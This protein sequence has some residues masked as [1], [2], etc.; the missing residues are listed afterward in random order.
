MIPRIGLVLNSFCNGY[1]G[2]GVYRPLRIE[3]LGA[4]WIVARDKDGT[5]RF[6]SFGSTE[7]MES[8]LDMWYR[9]EDQIGENSKDLLRNAP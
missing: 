2:S 8:L 4:D 3:A 5:P 7:M 1:F 9:E 6:V